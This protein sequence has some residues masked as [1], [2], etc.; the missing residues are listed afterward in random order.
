M[1]NFFVIPTMLLRRSI[2]MRGSSL[3]SLT[4]GTLF[5]H[6]NQAVALLGASVAEK[7]DYQRL[8]CGKRA[9]CHAANGNFTTEMSHPQCTKGTICSLAHSCSQPQ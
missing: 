7:L 9:D 2:T 1:R 8:H 6:A 5:L 4:A 3:L